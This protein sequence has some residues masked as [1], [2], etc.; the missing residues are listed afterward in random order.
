M[1]VLVTGAKGQLGFDVVNELNKR[2][3]DSVGLDIEDMDITDKASV[4]S[5]IKSV[6]PDAVIHC[7]AWTAVDDA[8]DYDNRKKVWSINVDGT[9]NIAEVCHDIDCKMLYIS[10]DY[11]FEGT[12]IFP[13]KTDSEKLYP[14]NYY[15]ESK[16]EG[17]NVVKDLLDKYFIVRTAWVFGSNGHNFVK[18]MLK[19][20]DT[21]D[22]L[23]VID[24]QF[25]TPTYTY[26]LARLLVDMIETEKYGIY[27][28]TNEGG[29]ITWYNFACYIFRFA[30][31]D[32]EVIPVTSL[33]Y[34]YSKALRPHNSRLDKSKL[35]ENG[36][37]PLP[38]WDDALERYIKEILE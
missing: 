23:R 15:G 8:E 4:Y 11:V 13:W 21:H 7:A 34:G 27:H 9:K 37:T 38:D 28:A 33:E 20:S 35:R 36:F 19:L 2:G 25:G 16:L 31:R 14:L 10:T 6:N 24:D 29:F 1:K 18:T 26:D 32:V 17:E 3:Y 5:V 30:K 12:G 22:T